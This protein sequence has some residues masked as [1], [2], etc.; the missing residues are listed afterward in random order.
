MWTAGIAWDGAGYQIACLH[1]DGRAVPASRF[2]AND[3]TGMVAHLHAVCG[4]G[5]TCVVDSTNGLLDGP[6]RDAGLRVLRADP[7]ELP[8][9]PAGGS[10]PAHLLARRGAAA[11]GRLA[12]T[13]TRSGSLKGRDLDDMY[14]TSATIAEALA[15]E[16]RCL[17]RGPAHLRQVALTFD[18]G[19][20]GADTGRILDV[21][22][23]YGVPATFFCV[24]LH[25]QAEP[26]TV[27]R[28]ADE[29][30]A[31]GNHT[32]SH[33][34][35]P[36]LTRDEVLFQLD[37]TA[38]AIADVTGQQPTLV[39]PPYGAQTPD[40]M[41]WVADHGLTTVL[42][43]QDTNDWSQPGAEAIRANALTG[44]GNGSVVLMHDAGGDR[45][46][47]VA[48]LPGVIEALLADGYSLVTV[49][50]M[51]TGGA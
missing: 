3:I 2:R 9:R 7:W 27:A 45:S 16:G 50:Q 22:R 33:P 5:V 51:L 46:Q 34:F 14:R 13:D 29:G 15:R 38:R 18:D 24:G 47:T 43:G 6:L 21:L 48:A 28:I 25:A 40:S 39:R 49:D 42:W 12:E 8:A 10:V 35:L 30:H 20:G 41:A 31:I 37:A 26:A 36:D 19:P 11:E 44:I 4:T 17:K 32:W 23:D 1:A